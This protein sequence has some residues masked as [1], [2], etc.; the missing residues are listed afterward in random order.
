M[1]LLMPSLSSYL[2]IVC[3]RRSFALLGLTNEVGVS[4]TFLKAEAH[5]GTLFGVTAIA[6]T[7]RET[8]ILSRADLWN[9]V[10]WRQKEGKK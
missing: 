8:S 10:H 5:T 2:G 7:L 4:K 1:K 6:L 3:T 9:V